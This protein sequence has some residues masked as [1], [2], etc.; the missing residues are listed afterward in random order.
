MKL[1]EVKR[2]K[3][4]LE[5]RN[6]GGIGM[7]KLYQHGTL[8]ALMAGL[9][10]GTATVDELLTKGDFGIA[11]LTGSDG[12]VIFLEGEA[13]HANEHGDFVQLSGE[14]RTPYATIAHFK[15]D[16]QFNVKHMDSNTF[17]DKVKSEML[18]EN[19]FSAVKATGTFKSMHVRMMPKQDPPYTKLMDSVESQPEVTLMDIKG[20]IVGFFTPDLFHGIGAKG[21]HIHFVDDQNMYGGH[22]LDFEIENASIELQNFETFEQH[23]PIDNKA[24]LNEKIDEEMVRR[25]IEK[26]E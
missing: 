7:H 2:W 25:D 4:F 12:E 26:G 20:T 13:F 15:S 23:F 24:F 18:S 5:K 3:T 16:H 1:V 11:T 21:F 14:E 10:E 6:N 9:L 19:L 8:G 17:K 22:I